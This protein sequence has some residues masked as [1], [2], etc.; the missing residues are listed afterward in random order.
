MALRRTPLLFEAVNDPSDLTHSHNTPLA[1][2]EEP[3]Y[4]Q[5]AAQSGYHPVHDT[6]D[7]DLRGAWKQGATPDARRHLTDQFKK[8]NHPT[9]S[10]QSQYATPG[11]GKWATQPDGS[12]HFHAGPDNL[13]HHSP[14]DLQTY[15]K[16]REAGNKLLLPTPSQAQESADPTGSDF[17]QRMGALSTLRAD[18]QRGRRLYAKDYLSKLPYPESAHAWTK[19]TGAHPDDVFHD[20]TRRLPGTP[21][22]SESAQA[23]IRQYHPQIMA[24]P[25]HRDNATLLAIHMDHDL[26]FQKWYLN[27]LPK[28]AGMYKHLFDRV[29]INS[30]RPQRYGTQS[31]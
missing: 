9:F 1:P 17:K 24:Q 8:P 29:A 14:S 27:K 5:W 28:N 2:H 6:Y 13:I 26:P 11:A 23:I 18:D 21:S 4:Q 10:N 16:Q 25:Q 7:Y 19:D 22:R 15:F 12:Y 20:K 31:V 30:G 3:Q